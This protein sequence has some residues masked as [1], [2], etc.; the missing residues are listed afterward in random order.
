MDKAKES[1]KRLE[2][3]SK[4]LGADLFGVADVSGIRDKFFFSSDLTNGLNRAISIG[5]RLLD[6][7]LEEIEDKPTPLYHHHYRQINLLIDR[8]SLRGSS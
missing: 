5:V 1:Y 2:K 6:T 3:F 7:V 4:G 8:I